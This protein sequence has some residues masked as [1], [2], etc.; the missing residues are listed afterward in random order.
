MKKKLISAGL[1][2]AM[3]VMQ[4]MSVSAAGSKTTGAAVTG[5]AQAYYEIRELTDDIFAEEGIDQDVIDLIKAVN[6]GTKTLD[7]IAAAQPE[8]AD[9]LKGM[10]LVTPIFDLIPINGGIRNADDTEYIVQKI[11][12]STL[13]QGMS[14]VKVLHYSTERKVWEI[15]NPTNVDLEGKTVE[16]NFTDLSPVAI[17]AKVD[18][19]QA[20]NNAE[21]TAPKTGVESNHAWMAWG[22]AAVVLFAAAAV[23]ACRRKRA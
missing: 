7:D 10:S 18:A 17:I 23:V 4:V 20:V 3:L 11:S 15:I 5:N 9:E 12:V 1:L 19:S 14:G 8:I 16:V 2:I 6:D 21:G 13:A 22:C